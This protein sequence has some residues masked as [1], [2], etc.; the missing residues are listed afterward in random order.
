MRSK[1]YMFALGILCIIVIT[2][3]EKVA[4]LDDKPIYI[5]AVKDSTFKETFAKLNLGILFNFRYQVNDS[6]QTWIKYWVEGYKHGKFVGNLI[7]IN[8]SIPSQENGGNEIVGDLTFGIMD[9]APGN[10]FI[11]LHA[12][13]AGRQPFVHNHDIFMNEEPVGSNWEYTVGTK[14][15][16][17]NMDEEILLAVYREWL[18]STRVYDYLDPVG[19]HEAI[20]Q[21]YTVLLAKFKVEKKSAP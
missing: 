9:P 16:G 17:L 8:T 19:L 14:K 7:E 13:H 5:S 2:S 10:P 6:E 1:Y 21:G 15:V 12:S 11:L 4:S 20:D 3:C 18:G